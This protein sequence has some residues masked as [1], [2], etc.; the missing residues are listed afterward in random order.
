MRVLYCI[1]VTKAGAIW[2]AGVFVLAILFG[3]THPAGAETSSW[4]QKEKSQSQIEQKK[5]RPKKSARRTPTPKT[6]KKRTGN[7]AAYIAFDQG[8]YLT[9]LELA[10]ADAKKGDPAAHTLIGRIYGEGFGVSRNAAAAAQWY[11]RGA[12]LG[13]VNAMFALGLIA[14][15][16]RGVKKDRL[17]AAEMFEQAARK[18]HAEANYNLGLLFLNGDGKPENPPH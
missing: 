10:Q 1:A 5:S 9:A 14:A 8:K 17:A 16:G 15:Q 2:L 11:T 13:D 6:G 12:E 3:G 18:G 7:S 4:A